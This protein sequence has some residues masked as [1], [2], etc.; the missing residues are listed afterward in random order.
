MFDNWVLGFGFWV[1]DLELERLNLG[2]GLMS[3]RRHC[4]PCS[5]LNKRRQLIS[6]ITRESVNFFQDDTQVKCENARALGQW[7]SLA[8]N[9]ISH[10]YS[11]TCACSKPSQNC[12]TVGQNGQMRTDGAQN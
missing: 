7:D 1:F 9:V 5:G 4:K 2:V 6:G 11:I 10:W 8:A 3:K 12:R